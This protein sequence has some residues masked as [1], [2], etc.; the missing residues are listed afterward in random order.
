MTA[1]NVTEISSGAKSPNE[2]C[3][4]TSSLQILLHAMQCPIVQETGLSNLSYMAI[5]HF[6]LKKGNIKSP[7]TSEIQLI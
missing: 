1:V 4:L 2:P 3:S 5:C 7:D 6:T